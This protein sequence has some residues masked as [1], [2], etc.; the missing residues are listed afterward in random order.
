ML[1]MNQLGMNL[2][3]N[4]LLERVKTGVVQV[5]A[6]RRAG[7]AQTEGGAGSGIVWM[8]RE[9]IS[10]HHVISGKSRVRVIT[11]DG[12]ELEARVIDS[13]ARLDLARLEVSEDLLP[14]DIGD[15]S[16]LRVGELV[17]A[18]GHPW[19]EPWVSTAGIVSGLGVVKMPGGGSSRDLIRSDVQL[20]PGNSGG[21][22][23]NARG[24]V[25]GINSM[26][27][28]G[29]L[30]VAVPVHVAQSW[31]LKAARPKIGVRL[32][33]V[34]IQQGLE[35]ESRLMIVHLEPDGP[36]MRAGLNIGDV[37]LEANGQLL[38]A[39]DA[40]LD[41]LKLGGNQTLELRVL[42]AGKSQAI[43]VLPE[44]EVRAA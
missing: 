10:N 8:K 24:E 29:D 9:I 26:I 41:A 23:V 15:S 42:R 27:W 1:G 19:G 22:L 32:Q 28:Q 44:S 36:A 12:R 40:L 18:V 4:E 13:D 34:L 25:V 2:Q 5:R 31:R 43:T 30:G 21:A 16:R 17:F 33:P 6:S 38:R 14:L 39:G 35:R 3:S 20:R 7:G 37:L 11:H